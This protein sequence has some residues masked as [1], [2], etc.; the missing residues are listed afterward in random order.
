MNSISTPT[1]TLRLGDLI[2]FSVAA[3][4]VLDPLLSTAAIGVSSLFWWAFMAVAFFLPFG[5]ISAELGT[6]YPEQG[7]VYA[8]VRDAFGKTMGARVAWAYWVNV[9]LWNPAQFI[10]LITILGQLFFPDMP[11]G[12]QVG[13][14]ILLCWVTVALNVVSLDIGKWVPNLGALL[15]ILIILALIGGGVAHYLDKGSANAIGLRELMPS[16]DAS[17]KYVPVVIYGMLGF[18]LMCA[19]SRDIQ[20][21]QQNLPFAILWSGLIIAGLYALGTLGILIALP[22][23]DLNIVEGLVAAFYAMFGDSQFGVLIAILLGIGAVFTIFSSAVTWCL[24]TNRAMAETAVEG[25]FPGPLGKE[26][27]KFRT[28]VGAAVAG[29][30]LS[31]LVL[32][33][34]G[35]LVATNEELFWALF[36]CSAVLF[37]LPYIVMMAAYVRLRFR[38]AG[39]TRPFAVPGGDLFASLLALWCLAVLVFS[40]VLLVYVPEVGFDSWVFFGALAVLLIGEV[41][42]HYSRK[43]SNLGA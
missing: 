23:E 31:T 8:W 12:L 22:V 21:P 7:G 5:L 14:C 40:L 9:S 26:H 41:A 34:Y 30:V 43:R 25:A 6:T 1:P 39:V 28:P 33:I 38:D 18:E 3:I 10:L 42:I 24:G 4:L 19:G 35:N 13:L 29:G 37:L 20:N 11:L 17:L 32:I 27:Q 2:L 36:A 15:K 16:F